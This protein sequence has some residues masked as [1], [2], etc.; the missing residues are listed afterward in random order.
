MVNTVTG[1][2]TA[3]QLGKTLMHEHFIFGY[4]GYVGDQSCAPFQPEQAVATCTDAA[5]AVRL[6][7]VQTVVDATPNDCGRDVR[8]LKKIS[9][10]SGVNI[11]CSTGYYFEDEGA[12]AYFKFRNAIGN[13]EQEIYELMLKEITEGIDQTDIKAGVIKLASSKGKITDY[14]QLFF[15][16][17][18]R[19]HRQTKVNIITHT[20]HGTMGPEQADFLI[21]AGVDPHKIMIGHM[22]GNMDLR[23]VVSVLE[24]GVYIA[25]DR[26]GLEGLLD[27]PRDRE[28]EALVVALLALGY[29]D[30]IMFSHDTVNV[31]RGRPMVFPPA[32]AQTME[33]ATMTRL[34]DVILPD[35]KHMGVTD[36]QIEKIMVK[37][38]ANFFLNA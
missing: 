5:H 29:E 26:F 20:Q 35:L 36:A 1:P 19:V 12:C 30:Q 2:K 34:F 10:Q 16:A 23:Y 31:M 17:A 24:R 8:L 11:I 32:L 33:N 13:A 27:T 4:P 25:F 6:R 28:R 38:P 3:S 7:G 21:K 14:E 15:R 18:A 22:C 37:N 9:E